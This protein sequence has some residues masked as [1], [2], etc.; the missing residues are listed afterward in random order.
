MFP[1][2]KKLGNVFGWIIILG[3]D[4]AFAAMTIFSLKRLWV[5]EENQEGFVVAM[6]VL[7]DVGLGAM[8]IVFGIY[9]IICLWKYFSKKLAGMA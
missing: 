7:T 8:E 2:R 9:V 3:S 6:M 4:L 1:V 5:L